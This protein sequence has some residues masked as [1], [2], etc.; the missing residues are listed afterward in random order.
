MSES[1]QAVKEKESEVKVLT[2]KVTN[3]ES[4]KAR[5]ESAL[6]EEKTRA[7]SAL[8]DE[9]ARVKSTL[10][11]EKVRAELLSKMKKQRLPHFRL[12]LKN[13]IGET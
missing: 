10:K 13:Y 1:L 2:E 9:K 12:K 8:K 7:E 3:A 6:E 5:A 4:A 11:E